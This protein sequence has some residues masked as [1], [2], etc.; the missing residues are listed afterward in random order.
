MQFTK[1]QTEY[2]M[3]TTNNFQTTVFSTESAGCCL[4]LE[5]DD[6]LVRPM[7]LAL[8]CGVDG[9]M[10]RTPTPAEKALSASETVMTSFPFWN[11]GI[12]LGCTFEQTGHVSDILGTPILN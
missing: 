7:S 12:E 10:F 8:P 11:I 3:S 6:H 5:A 1:N 2:G 9:G 4:N